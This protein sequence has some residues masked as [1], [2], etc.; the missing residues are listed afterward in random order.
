MAFVFALDFAM[1]SNI[2]EQVVLLVLQLGVI[3]FA[4]RLVGKLASLAHIPSVLGELVTGILLGPYLLGSI[5]LPYFPHGFFPLMADGGIPV[6]LPLYSLATLGSIVLLFQSGLETDF[7][8]FFRYS[9]AGTIVGLG[10][11]IFSFAF[12]ELLGHWIYH[13]SLMDPRALFLGIL[14]TATSV[15]ISARILSDR[16]AIDSPEGTTIMAAAVIDDVLG[17]ICLAIVM[18]LVGSTADATSVSWKQIGLIALKSVAIWLGFTCIGLACAHYLARFMKTFHSKTSYA[19]LSLSLALLLSGIME[20]CGLAMIIGAYTAGLSLS[21]SDLA[22][23]I[24]LRLEG[25]YHFLVPVFFVVMG[26]MVDVRILADGTCLKFGF[27]F[28]ILAILGKVLGCLLPALF[29]NFTP[30]GALRIGVGMIPRGE[31]ALIIAGIGATTTMFFGDGTVGPIVDSQLFGEAIIMTLVTTIVAPPLLM[32]TLNLKGKSVRKERPDAQSIHLEFPMPSLVVRDFLIRLLIDNFRQEGF[33]HSDYAKDYTVINFRK[34]NNSFVMTVADGLICFECAKLLVPTIT[35]IFNETTYELHQDVEELRRLAVPK[36]LVGDARNFPG[37][38]P[39]TGNDD[40]KLSEIIPQNCALVDLQSTSYEETL[41]EL[42]R[43]LFRCGYV[44]DFDL[45]LKDIM[46]REALSSTIL[47]GGLAMPH[48]RSTTVGRL[49]SVV[50]IFPSGKELEVNGQQVRLVMMT[51]APKDQ[52][53]PY[54][55]YIAHQASRLCA[56][57][58]LSFLDKCNT[59]KALRAFFCS[60]M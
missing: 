34:E 3:V 60:E 7:R 43:H 20:H 33:R 49:I 17:I 58:D 42:T 52:P 11:V 25:I 21:R 27:L 55:Q 4:A 53:G 16:K 41:K 5:H 8:T 31:V 57:N 40:I 51:I 44:S 12:G 59:G 10:G 26:M 9:L 29:M 36:S 1:E 28:A 48:A 54:M 38:I 39:F 30:L 50:A 23:S 14:S 18:G 13:C 15:G 24:R 19:I 47:D 6:S 56:Q 2:T 35:T 46:E 22:F 45:C 37:I 32:M